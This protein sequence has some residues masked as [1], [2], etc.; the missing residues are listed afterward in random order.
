[1][2]RFPVITQGL[3]LGGQD[4]VRVEITLD[5]LAGQFQH[6]LTVLDGQID[7]GHFD[8]F[9]GNRVLGGD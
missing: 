7:E 1:M 2:Y 4:G 9:G 5:I 6:A 8:L 3:R